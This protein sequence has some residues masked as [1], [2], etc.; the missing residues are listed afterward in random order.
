M[1]T[2]VSRYTVKL[3]CGAVVSAALRFLVPG[4]VSVWVPIP[5]LKQKLEGF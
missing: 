4:P 3:K 1:V 2:L 5:I